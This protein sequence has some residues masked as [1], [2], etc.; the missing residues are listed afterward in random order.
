MKFT[1]KLANAVKKN[2]SLLCVGLDTDHSSLPPDLGIF[3][4]NKMI[5]AFFDQIGCLLNQNIDL[6]HYRSLL[7]PRLIS[8]KLSVEY[9]DIQFP[10]SM[11]D[12]VA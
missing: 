1:E 12:A 9:L 4:F 3:E 8:G 11:E 5:R 10:K 2:N 7:L 6:K